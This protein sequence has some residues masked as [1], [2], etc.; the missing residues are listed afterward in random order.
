[1]DRGVIRRGRRIVRDTKPLL[2]RRHRRQRAQGVFGLVYRVFTG[3][4]LGN[5]CRWA[6]G[7]AERER[8]QLASRSPLIRGRAVRELP[9]RA[10]GCPIIAV[11]AQVVE[12]VVDVELAQGAS[13]PALC[14]GRLASRRARSITSASA[15]SCPTCSCW[16]CCSRRRA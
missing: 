13:G 15:C 2:A 3:L 16:C 7:E 9:P 1:F 14:D 11:D 4:A 12:D 8:V 6:A 10:L 5:L